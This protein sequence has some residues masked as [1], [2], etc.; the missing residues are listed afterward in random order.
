[1]VDVCGDDHP[2]TGDFA[3]NEVRVEVFPL[4]V[5]AQR[6]TWPEKKERTSQWFDWEDAA[7]AVEEEELAALIRALARQTLKG[8]ARPKAAG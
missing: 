5:T 3:T 2:A 6:R 8:K 1:M 4:K 7:E